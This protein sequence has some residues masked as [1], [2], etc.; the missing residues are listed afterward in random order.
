MAKGKQ[1]DTKSRERLSRNE[2]KLIK[3]K[4]STSKFTADLCILMD[5]VTERSWRDLH[6]LLVKIAQFDITLSKD[7][8]E[9]IA[10][11]NT[12]VSELK[13]VAGEHGIKPQARLK[14]LENLDPSRLTTRK[15]D[16]SSPLALEN[17]FAGMA[18]GGSAGSTFAAGNNNDMHFPPGSTAGQGLGGFPVQVKSASG[19]YDGSASGHTSAA[20]GGAPSTLDMMAI[21][22]SAA[23]APTMDALSA[24]F[25]PRASMTAP[26]SSGGSFQNGRDRNQPQHC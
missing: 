20:T 19:S 18:L 9:A 5:E 14:D 1:V 21:N 8:A 15:S 24:A 2:D 4:E 3:S 22:A 11:L 16:G 26:P 12:V 25:G 13:R 6:P 17:G 7:E 10:S 23:P